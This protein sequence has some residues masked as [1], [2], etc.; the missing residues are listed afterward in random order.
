[1]ALIGVVMAGMAEMQPR[2]NRSQCSSSR[3]LWWSKYRIV[4]L[5]AC[6][7]VCV[8]VKDCGFLSHLVPIVDV[9]Y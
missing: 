6:A 8:F 1:M 2:V 5:Y 9:Y 3:L 4:S 7:C